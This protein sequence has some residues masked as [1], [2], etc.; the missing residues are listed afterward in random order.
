MYIEELLQLVK[1]KFVGLFGEALKGSKTPALPSNEPYPFSKYFNKLHEDCE[2]KS[3]E[4]KVT[5]QV[6]R[7]FSE[8][9][10]G[11]QKMDR[12]DDENK[13]KKKKGKGK[14]DRT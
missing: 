7:S 1:D 14:E 6:Q 10:K 5:P 12:G 3:R 8:T 4:K 13:K 9:K 11:K 2:L